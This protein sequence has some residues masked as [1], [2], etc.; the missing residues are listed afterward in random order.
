MKG[1]VRGEKG[2]GILALVLVLLVVA[3][4]ILAPLLGLM[5]TGLM[6]GQI[7]EKK[8]NDYYAAD[9]GVTDAIS[10]IQANSLKFDVGNYSYLEPFSVN[11]ES[12]NTVVY[13]HDWDPTCG[14]NFTY[15]VLSTSTN[16]NGS[17]TTIDAHLS[18][19]YLD[20]SGLLNNAI[21]SNDTIEIKP[22]NYVSG[23]VWLPDRENLKTSPGVTIN[24]TVEDSNNMTIDWPTY[25]QLSA[26][27]LADVKNAT[28]PGG[29]IDLLGAT[30]SIGPCYRRYGS[31]DLT[32]DNTQ[33]G[34]AILKLNGTVYVTGDLTFS[35]AGAKNY[36]LDL[37]KQT[38]FADGS[39]GFPSNVVSVRGPGCLIA[40]GNINF[41]PSVLGNDFVL[42]YSMT[43]A[44][45]FHP[46][47]NFT[48]CIA[49]S[50][51]VQLQP[52]NTIAWISPDGKGLNVPW[53]V[54]NYTKL[55]PVTGL[56]IDS[57]EI[58]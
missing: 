32:I 52:G 26:Y 48:G 8:T 31:G 57:W 18:V 54:G 46:S 58:S 29:S 47:G 24:G 38:I 3:G 19:S 22:G 51:D 10:R 45:E 41:Q 37:N 53:G 23:D 20:L 5:G 14:E 13:R 4:V 42:V 12:V 27:Y 36:T 50:V 1:F 49:G 15:Q 44:V 40:K 35:Q 55:P 11:N 17:G 16:D 56:R 21:V 39:I 33:Q 2:A 6:S 25:E 43:G 9:A 34:N 7:Y 30:V 28:D